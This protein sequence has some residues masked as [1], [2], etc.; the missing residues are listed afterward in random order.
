M[1]PEA[2]RSLGLRPG[3]QRHAAANKKPAT[4]EEG[5]TRRGARTRNAEA[6]LGIAQNLRGGKNKRPAA[7]WAEESSSEDKNTQKN[8]RGCEN[9][10][11]TTAHLASAGPVPLNPMRLPIRLNLDQASL[12][13]FIGEN[14]LQCGAP[15]RL[16]AAA[17]RK[18]RRA[19]T[20]TL[21]KA[22]S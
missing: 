10:L 16:L 17:L 20:R 11:S 4:R 18:R 8:R 6:E 9:P 7:K 13:N 15:A 12:R 2:A 14:G 19:Q 21:S 3:T 22:P 5:A 1:M